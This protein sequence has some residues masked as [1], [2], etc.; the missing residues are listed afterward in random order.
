MAGARLVFAHAG[1]SAATEAPPRRRDACIATPALFV[2]SSTFP[3]LF[4][5]AFVLHRSDRLQRSIVLT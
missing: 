1:G 2:G 3:S 4:T 5:A